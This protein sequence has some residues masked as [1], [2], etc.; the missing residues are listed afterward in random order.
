MVGLIDGLVAYNATRGCIL[1]LF[2]KFIA[3][4]KLHPL[5]SKGCN[6]QAIQVEVNDDFFCPW[7]SAGQRNAA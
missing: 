6:M 7:C 4:H 5:P 2:Y 1:D 3:T